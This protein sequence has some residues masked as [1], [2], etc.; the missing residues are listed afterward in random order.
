MAKEWFRQ[1]GEPT[2]RRMILRG[3]FSPVGDYED[4]W[5]KQVMRGID[6][7]ISWDTN[8]FEYESILGK[9]HVTLKNSMRIEDIPD[10]GIFV[11]V[12]IGIYRDGYHIKIIPDRSVLDINKHVFD[13]DMNRNFAWT[14]QTSLVAPIA[15]EIVG[16]LKTYRGKVENLS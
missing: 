11:D 16:R 5:W 1:K 15:N 2:F 12:V 10:R 9:S 14:Q 13:G 3:I 4:I 7:K 8:V 6:D